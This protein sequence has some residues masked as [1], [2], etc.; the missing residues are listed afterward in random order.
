MEG[1]YFLP[2][3]KAY[4]AY[5]HNEIKQDIF[6]FFLAVTDFLP[7]IFPLSLTVLYPV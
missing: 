3:K 1:S 6:E 4:E 7:F 5:F 2:W